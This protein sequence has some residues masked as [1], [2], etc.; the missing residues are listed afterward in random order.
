MRAAYPVGPSPDRA[1]TTAS[2]LPHSTMSQKGPLPPLAPLA[3]Q[4]ATTSALTAAKTAR[5]TCSVR[6]GI[7]P[8]WP[9]AGGPG[10]GR[11]AAG[12]GASRRLAAVRRAA[13]LVQAVREARLQ[14]PQL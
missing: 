14:R 1:T 10:C 4:A 8:G 2:A 3:A 12:G 13:A 6:S 9:L 7:A 5:R 11:R